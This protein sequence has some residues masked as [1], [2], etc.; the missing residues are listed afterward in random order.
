VKERSVCQDVRYHLEGPE[1]LES[2]STK[3]REGG[4]TAKPIKG[5]KKIELRREV[6]KLTK[7]IVFV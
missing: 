5:K 1:K 4:N 3:L 6:P 2:N 7:R